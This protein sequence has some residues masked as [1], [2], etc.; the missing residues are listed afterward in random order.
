MKKG[1][2]VKIKLTGKIGMILEELTS[3]NKGYVPGYWIRTPERYKAVKMF[4]F[5]VEE[6]K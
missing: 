3:D 2:L 4:G 6:R 5:E 1:D